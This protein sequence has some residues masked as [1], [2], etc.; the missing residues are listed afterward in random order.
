MIPKKQTFFKP[1]NSQIQNTTSPTNQQLFKYTIIL[2]STLIFFLLF[3]YALH[4]PINPL[5]QL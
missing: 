1:L 2:L 3:F 4:I 5:K